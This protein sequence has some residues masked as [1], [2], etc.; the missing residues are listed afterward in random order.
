MA[1][2]GRGQPVRAVILRGSLED[3]APPVGDFATHP[4]FIGLPPARDLSRRRNARQA[5]ISRGS[6]DAAGASFAF[7]NT[8]LG[9]V[10]EVAPGADPADDPDA[11]PWVDITEYVMS[12]DAVA[13]IR[14]TRGA[15]SER[16]QAPVATCSFQLNNRDGLFSTQNYLSSLVQLGLRRG[17]PVRIRIVDGPISSVRFVGRLDELPPRWDTSGNDRWVPVTAS[18]IMRRL[19]VGVRAGEPTS[20]V[21]VPPPITSA[22]QA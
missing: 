6:P 4:I 7:P 10:V 5:F 16:S 3:A 11:W 20:G 18:G 21:T 9:I 1:R 19:G 15:T 22:S 12:R 14:I 17:T 8:I 13:P 2:L